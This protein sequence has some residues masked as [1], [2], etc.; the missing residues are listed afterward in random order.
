MSPWSS[1]VSDIARNG[2]L[3]KIQRLE[4]GIAFYVAGEFSEA[5]AQLIA[6]GLHDRMTQ[7]VLG[8]L[9]QAAGLFSHAEPNTLTAIDVLGGG[10]AALEKANAEL[11][12]A[13]AEAETDSLVNALQ[14][15]A[16]N[17]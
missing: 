16:S 4:R 14:G 6:E 10:R 5:E 12:V 11:C 17:T 9:E 8:S 1:K 13:L 2:G 3:A 7:I 15:F